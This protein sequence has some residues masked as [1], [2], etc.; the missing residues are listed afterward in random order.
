VTR[1]VIFSPEARSDLWRIDLYIAEHSGSEQALAYT[2][3]I[4]AHCMGLANFPERGTRRGDLRPGLRIIGFERRV[5]IAFH[6]K[7]DAVVIDRILY[8]G[9]DLR[10]AFAED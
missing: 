1:Q 3:R 7:P 10:K 6:V 9:R 8:G 2:S 4:H 5:T